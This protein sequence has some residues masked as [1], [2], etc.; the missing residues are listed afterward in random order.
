MAK[1]L[2]VDDHVP[3]RA[4]LGETV[5]ALKHDV[6]EAG[7]GAEA[8]DI[9][10]SVTPD[11]VFLDL[12]MPD[13]SG[14]EVLK[15]IR[16]SLKL[17]NL[18]VVILTAYADSAN[19]IEAM[20]LGA[21]DHLTK[22]INRDDV[23]R[24][25]VRALDGS[26]QNEI[27]ESVTAVADLER[28]IGESPAFREVEKLMGLALSTSTPVLIFG[29]AGTGKEKIARTLYEHSDLEEPFLTIP[30]SSP[31]VGF[32]CWSEQGMVY[33]EELADLEPSAQAQLLTLL[34]DDNS[35]PRVIS[36]SSCD[37]DVLVRQGNLREDLFYRLSVFPIKVP[38]LRDRASDILVLAEAF[39]NRDRTDNARR[40]TPAAAKALLE[41]SWPGNVRE[42]MNTISRAA[43]VARG[44]VVDFE[45][46]SFAQQIAI[47]EVSL[48][49]I[50]Q[51][52][53]Y[54]AIARVEKMLLEKAL[55]KA[56]GNRTEAA[57]TLG[58]NRQ[59]LY[60]KLKEHGIE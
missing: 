4:V 28:L 2:I 52:D 36:S 10:K 1:I 3:F 11:V 20:K 35:N 12:R 57:R 49:D 9:L 29:E 24:I 27:K 31:E 39:L 26:G 53:Y 37:L 59:L 58:I 16:D 46:L 55:K 23:R 43:V 21:F 38:P 50:L 22:P 48:N 33:L 6:L 42:L 25:I 34:R 47:P 60:S 51:L 30:C 32:T 40:L 5:T 13:M 15:A 17:K 8:L 7:S 56:V 41:Y 54:G 44:L 45:D 14:L 18:P 19:T